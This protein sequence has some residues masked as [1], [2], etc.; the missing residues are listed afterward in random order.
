VFAEAI[1]LKLGSSVAKSV[2]SLW[3]Q[4]DVVLLN[5]ADTTIDA[6]IGEIP[7]LGILERRRLS[8]QF[9]RMAESV[10]EKLEPFLEIEFGGLSENERKASVLAVS[11]SFE[12]ARVS[13]QVLLSR[14][15]EPLRLEDYIRATKVK[16]RASLNEAAGLLYDH[17]LRETCNYAVEIAVT[18]PQFSS[19]AAR[20]SLRRESEIIELI[21]TVLA[22]LPDPAITGEEESD[23]DFQFET[24][25]R[26]TV[27]RKLDNLELFGLDVS[28][29]SKRYALSVAYITL[30]ASEPGKHNAGGEDE[31]VRVNKALADNQRMLVRGDAGSGKTT[32]LQWLAVSSARKSFDDVLKEW[33]NSIPFFIQLR[34]YAGRELPRPE[35]FVGS[36][37]PNEAG[38]MPEGWVHRQLESGRALVLIDGVDELS[39]EDRKRARDWVTD[40]TTSFDQIRVVVTSRPTTS[41]DWL[42]VAKFKHCSLQ[43]MTLGDVDAFV[44]HWHAAIGSALPSESAQLDEMSERLMAT[45]RAR[46]PVR[47]LATS[48]L[49]CAMICALHR[50]RSEQ[51][52]EDRMELYRVALELLLERRDLERRVVTSDIRLTLKEKQIFLRDL[53]YWLELNNYSDAEEDGIVARIE[54]KLSSMQ[55]IRGEDP[56]SIFR[57]LLERSGILRMPTLG[58]IDFVH[59]TFQEYLA[60]EEIVEQENIGMLIDNAENDHWREVIILAAG[61]ASLR[62][63][64]ELLDGLLRRGNNESNQRHR[65]HLLACACLETS[66]EVGPELSSKLQGALTSLLPPKNMTEAQAVASAGSLAVPLLRGFQNERVRVVAACVRA[67]ALAGGEEA[68][69]AL[70][71][72]AN[73]RRITVWEEL[74]RTWSALYFDPAEFSERVLAKQKEYPYI[75][76]DNTFLIPSLRFLPNLRELRILARIDQGDLTILTELQNLE[77]L[78]IETGSKLNDLS[79]LASLKS[80]KTLNIRDGISIGD[81]TPLSVLTQLDGLYLARSGITDLSPLRGLASLKELNITGCKVAELDP[82]SN[83]TQLTS[84][85]AG[86]T[87]IDN[88]S[89]LENCHFLT[90]CRVGNCPITD[91]T[92]LVNAEH[93]Q[94]LMLRGTKISDLS[95][96]GNLGKLKW[97]DITSCPVTDL[98]PLSRLANLGSLSLSYNPQIFSSSLDPLF[99]SLT[100]LNVHVRSEDKPSDEA[101]APITS[102]NVRVRV[103][104]RLQKAENVSG[105]FKVTTLPR[106]AVSSSEGS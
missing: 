37:A 98:A 96:L 51:L 74:M 61:H 86:S 105:S 57:Y 56:Q 62:Q 97:L 47:S 58:R 19:Q 102:R 89:P 44:S 54:R 8:R 21:N 76:I 28:P 46:N 79:P 23:K 72:Y 103:Y 42:N 50:E 38:R 99:E 41:E 90:T 14:N 48:P 9:D 73:D 55:R 100:H 34:R 77:H 15:L 52:P 71:A 88:L 5:A 35:D 67:L 85:S 66:P 11:D 2:L 94:T 65:L 22:K 17:L 20:E 26:R 13:T 49:L 4:D 43:S 60:A 1:L 83:C 6:I 64:E 39:D 32:L 70:E 53:A 63:R 25:Y 80:L 27:A 104:E 81:L 40:L 45:L 78:V 3:L 33:N 31:Y 30:S 59:R 29:I 91:L 24:Q 16:E 75:K 12:K 95:P 92:P 106:R 69:T 93:L 10:A 36:V 68:L 87:R 18:L 84:L 7:N 101:W 82:I